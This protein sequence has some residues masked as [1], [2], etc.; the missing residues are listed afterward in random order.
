MKLK[1]RY[2][3]IDSE[4]TALVSRKCKCGHTLNI[5]NRYRR[6]ICPNCGRMVFLDK[7][8]QNSTLELKEGML[9]ESWRDFKGK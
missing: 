9:S 8:K 7:K 1:D 2:I 3:N 6:E 5:Y 4:Y